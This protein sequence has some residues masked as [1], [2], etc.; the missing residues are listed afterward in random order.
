MSIYGVTLLFICHRLFP[1]RHAVSIPAW[2]HLLPP[3]HALQWASSVGEGRLA[4]PSLIEPEL[5]E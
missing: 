1:R 2:A 4:L 3:E 5:G